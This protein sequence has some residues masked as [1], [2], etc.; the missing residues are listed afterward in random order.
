MIF[1]HFLSSR[2]NERIAWLIGCKQ[3]CIQTVFLSVAGMMNVICRALPHWWS[4]IVA[5]ARCLLCS[6][7]KHA[8]KCK[9]SIHSTL[10]F[11]RDTNLFL[12]KFARENF[13]SVCVEILLQ[14]VS[15]VFDVFI[16]RLL[17]RR[18]NIKSQMLRGQTSVC[19]NQTFHY[20]WSLLFRRL[21]F[22]ID[23]VN[24]DPAFRWLFSMVYIFL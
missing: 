3:G 2:W 9:R 18:Q 17:I 12:H 19:F 6:S 13:T 8:Q 4:G 1:F 10:C 16:Q 23:C 20:E 24:S 21:S 15:R 7:W 5:S 11:H 14:T 22:I